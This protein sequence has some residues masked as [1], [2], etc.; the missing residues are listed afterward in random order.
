MTLGTSAEVIEMSSDDVTRCVGRDNVIEICK[1]LG[2]T[3]HDTCITRANSELC[4][5]C[6][7]EIE[8]HYPECIME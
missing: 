6:Y 4:S 2:C 5:E 1:K 8:K 3:I 7:A